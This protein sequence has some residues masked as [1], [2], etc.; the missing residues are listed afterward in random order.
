MGSQRVRHD[1]ETKEEQEN[2]WDLIKPKNFYTERK[3][4]NKTKSKPTAWGEI[5]TSDMTDGGNIQN[6]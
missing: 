4:V 1:L 5:F 3:F 2:T 6:I